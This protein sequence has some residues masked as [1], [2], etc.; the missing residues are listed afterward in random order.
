MTPKL[1]YAMALVIFALA[2]A[3]THFGAWRGDSNGYFTIVRFFMGTATPIE[4]AQAGHWHGY[5]RPVVP[6][7]A[8][9]LAF[10]TGARS[11]I[12]IVNVA[13]LMIGTCFTYLL[14][15]RLF[16]NNL[17]GFIAGVCYASASPNLV[18]GVAILT[19][20]PGYA[21]LA[22]GFYWL[23][24]HFKPSWRSSVITGV[25]VG[26]ALLVKEITVILVAFLVIQLIFH[27]S[28]AYLKSVLIVV[29][30]A[31][32]MTSA[33]SFLVVGRTYLNFYGE[34][35]VYAGGS[36]EGPLAQPRAFLD[37]IIR[38]FYMCIPFAIV[39][40]FRLSDEQVK[41]H[42]K[43]LLAG[44]ALLLVFPWI[45]SRYT[46]I[47]F[48]AVISMTPIGLDHAASILASWSWSRFLTRSQWLQLITIAIVVC[49][50]LTFIKFVNLPYLSG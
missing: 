17:Y 6:A 2:E 48:P 5:L 15:S 45:D 32:I 46:F 20:G 26:T 49:T 3:L 39:G 40:F 33:W 9:P 7:L 18:W 21:M 27:R 34:A 22:V 44:L 19:D 24:Y 8:A 29:S 10:L 42:V 36:Y 4:W 12:A 31:A 14:V 1:N 28:W 16:S 38:A 50:N 13:F 25:L 35:V 37:S 41:T 11:A 30:I 43:L 47:L 23:L